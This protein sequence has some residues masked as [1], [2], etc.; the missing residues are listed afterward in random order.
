MND[1]Q[2]KFVEYLVSF[3]ESAVEC[4]LAEHKCENLEVRKMLYEATYDMAVSIM[5][6]I[7]G[8][9]NFSSEKLDIINT[10]TGNHLKEDP[11]VELH[12]ILDGRM[13]N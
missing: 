10:V 4:C 12:D 3:Q 2:N 11:F 9:S 5:E 13:K 8:Y 6:L 1:L 7:D